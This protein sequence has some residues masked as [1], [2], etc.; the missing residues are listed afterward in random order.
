MTKSTLITMLQA[1][2][3][4]R[5]HSKCLHVQYTT[6]PQKRHCCIRALVPKCKIKDKMKMILADYEARLSHSQEWAAMAYYVS[7]G[8]RWRSLTKPYHAKYSFRCIRSSHRL[9]CKA[10]LIDQSSD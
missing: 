3:T 8:F 7:V 10:L 6:L 4:R 5:S 1:S 2:L 9:K